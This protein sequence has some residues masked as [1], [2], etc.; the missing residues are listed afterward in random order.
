MSSI[1]RKVLG[2]L[3]VYSPSSNLLIILATAYHHCSANSQHVILLYIRPRVVLTY[4]IDAGTTAIAYLVMLILLSRQMQRSR[5]P[6][7]I[8][9]ISFW[10]FLV[11]STVDALSFAGHTV[12]ALVADGKPSLSL[13]TPAFL[14]C[15]LFANEAVRLREM[16]FAY[17][18]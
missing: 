17:L 13:I 11:Q 7:G 6:T 9:R 12:F 10:T 2:Q 8:S 14:A 3:S 1:K 15:V 16:S 4:R 18:P 5:T